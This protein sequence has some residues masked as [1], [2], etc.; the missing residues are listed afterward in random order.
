[1]RLCG[2]AFS[3]TDRLFGVFE[4]FY[5]RF[6]P[7]HLLKVKLSYLTYEVL[8]HQDLQDQIHAQSVPPSYLTYEVLRP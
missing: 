8:R 3:G 7:L 1:M 5:R 6:S 4:G 2:I